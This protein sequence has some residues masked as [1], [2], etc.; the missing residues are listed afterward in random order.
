MLCHIW[1]IHFV[2]KHWTALSKDL[3]SRSRKR[4]PS[5]SP[6]FEVRSAVPLDDV[7][8]LEL[9]LAPDFKLAMVDGYVEVYP[10]RELK[11]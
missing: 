6:I 8:L 9:E 4:E 3:V 2:P 5:G 1:G 10:G 7:T 11:K